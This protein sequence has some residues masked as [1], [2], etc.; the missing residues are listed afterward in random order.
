MSRFIIPF[1]SAIPLMGLPLVVGCDR[2]VATEREVN[3][4]DDGTIVK[5]ETKVTED[6]EGDLTKTETKSVD[7]PA[8]TD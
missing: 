5:E 2:E 6:A 7:K 4:K 8:N 3:V 1:V